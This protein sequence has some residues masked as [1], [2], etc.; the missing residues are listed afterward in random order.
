MSY[1]LT[2]HLQHC[3]SNVSFWPVPE[4]HILGGSDPCNYYSP[5]I[6]NLW[7]QRYILKLLGADVLPGTSLPQTWAT[8]Q[9]PRKLPD[10]GVGT[11]PGALLPTARW[12]TMPTDKQ[13][14]ISW[15]PS[16]PSAILQAFAV[17]WIWWG[18][19]QVGAVG[20]QGLLLPK[21]PYCPH[22][23]TGHRRGQVLASTQHGY[24]YLE[25]CYYCH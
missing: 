25:T 21:G 8:W 22:N 13:L 17:R 19:C 3:S 9:R 16:K 5:T 6:T 10:R 23:S 15:W 14:R 7:D 24:H 1:F 4:D 12:T 18:T 20:E 2:L 11:Y